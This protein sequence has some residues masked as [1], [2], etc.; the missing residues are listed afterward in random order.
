MTSKMHD[1]AIYNFMI[2]IKIKIKIKI[3][4]NF[5]FFKHH[6]QGGKYR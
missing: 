5:Q 6:S 3:F 1:I 4:N 2:E